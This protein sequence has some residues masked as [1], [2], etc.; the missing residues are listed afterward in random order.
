M[1]KHRNKWNTLKANMSFKSAFVEEIE[2]K[3]NN[4]SNT[5]PIEVNV[6]PHHYP[7]VSKSKKSLQTNHKEES[8]IEYALDKY[9][10][11]PSTKIPKLNLSKIPISSSSKNFHCDICKKLKICQAFPVES[12]KLF[13]KDSSTAT[14]VKCL[15]KKRPISSYLTFTI[16]Q[17]DS[18]SSMS[19]IDNDV[20]IKND[21]SKGV[22]EQNSNETG[23][24]F[25]SRQEALKLAPWVEH[26]TDWE[27]ALV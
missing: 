22:A 5:K 9:N 6:A 15:N 16:E 12:H 1:P 10:I 20:V 21:G 13:V 2:A 23:S 26:L 11:S 4:P 19:S 3:M 14:C 24:N 8:I 18:Q 27:F 17:S 7:P 25:I